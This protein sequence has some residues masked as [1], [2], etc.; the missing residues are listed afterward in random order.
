MNSRRAGSTRTSSQFVSAPQLL[1][2]R[3]NTRQL[4]STPGHQ[5]TELAQRI[6]SS[7]HPSSSSK[8][9]GNQ[10]PFTSISVPSTKKILVAQ[11]FKKKKNVCVRWCVDTCVSMLHVGRAHMRQRR[12][13]ARTH[14]PTP[15]SNHMA[16]NSSSETS[17]RTYLG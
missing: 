9:T 7:E 3:S 17:R 2:T 8:R 4:N 12:R 16:V 11:Q 14:R 1:L 15:T 10:G 13:S 6:N 5:A